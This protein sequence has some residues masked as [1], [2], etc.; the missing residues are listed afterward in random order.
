MEGESRSEVSRWGNERTLAPAES[1][2]SY[3][4]LTGEV[5]LRW[6]K[7]ATI[8]GEKSCKSAIVQYFPY[9]ATLAD[10]FGDSVA[11]GPPGSLVPPDNIVRGVVHST[12]SFRPPDLQN[13]QRRK[14]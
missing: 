13:N 10:Q 9:L 7:V 2:V 4:L 5:S 14:D 12:V 6:V 8:C 11:A 3:L 1:T